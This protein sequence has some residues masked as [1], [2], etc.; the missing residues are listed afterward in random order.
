MVN[1]EFATPVRWQIRVAAIIPALLLSFMG[2][3]VA[4]RL[5]DVGARWTGALIGWITAWAFALAGL[6]IWERTSGRPILGRPT[7]DQPATIKFKS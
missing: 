2:L 3:A 1:D 4:I 7:P 6:A 5:N